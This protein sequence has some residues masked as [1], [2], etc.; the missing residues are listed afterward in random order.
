M[1]QRFMEFY[2]APNLF[3]ANYLLKRAH[4]TSSP[5]FVANEAREAFFHIN[6]TNA[7]GQ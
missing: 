2:R 4:E 1:Q 6:D 3:C 7:L 5:A